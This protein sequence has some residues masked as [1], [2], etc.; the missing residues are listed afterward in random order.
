[1]KPKR[2]LFNGKR[3][4]MKQSPRKGICKKCG[5]KGFTHIHHEKYDLIDPLAHTIELCPACHLKT[6]STSIPPIRV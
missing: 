6:R 1:M 4:T 2:I 3:P 5:R